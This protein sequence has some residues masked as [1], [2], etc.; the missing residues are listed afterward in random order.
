MYPN[1]INQQMNSSL[2]PKLTKCDDS[3][4]PDNNDFN[5]SLN[6]SVMI[7]RVVPKV[8]SSN[9]H[10]KHIQYHMSEIK[11]FS[12]KSKEV[13]SLQSPIC[14]FSRNKHSKSISINLT[15]VWNEGNNPFENIPGNQFTPLVIHV[16]KS[17]E[18]NDNV[19]LHPCKAS[20]TVNKNTSI[21]F[22]VTNK[23]TSSVDSDIIQA[24][25]FS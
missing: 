4:E 5:K 12:P 2:I 7:I 24:S 3:A 11:L 1:V 14:I 9:K 23:D 17:E 21:I 6:G 13:S 16:N 8:T 10:D 20:K 22:N 19:S 15:K 25:F 18:N